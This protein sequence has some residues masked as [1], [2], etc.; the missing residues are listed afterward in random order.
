MSGTDSL[1]I[2]FPMQYPKHFVEQDLWLYYRFSL[3]H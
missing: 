1:Q 2:S 3:S